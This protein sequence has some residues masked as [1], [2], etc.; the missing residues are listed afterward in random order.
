[1]AGT[2]RLA[3]ASYGRQFNRPTA[4]AYTDGQLLV[5]NSGNNTVT[6]INA[7]TMRVTRIMSSPAYHFSTPMGVGATGAAAW[8]TNET[9]QSVREIRANGVLY[10]WIRN[11]AYNDLPWPGPATIGAGYIFVASPPGHHR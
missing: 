3:G 10:Q 2:G 4:I 6:G 1:M 9:N 5:T 8:V 11:D 7:T